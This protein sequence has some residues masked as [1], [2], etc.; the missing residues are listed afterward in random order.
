MKILWHCFCK[1]RVYCIKYKSINMNQINDLYRINSRQSFRRLFV[2]VQHV[3]LDHSFKERVFSMA[4]SNR[5][6]ASG[7][8]FHSDFIQKARPFTKQY[9]SLLF[10]KPTSF[11]MNGCH[12]KWFICRSK[13]S[14]GHWWTT[15]KNPIVRNLSQFLLFYIFMF[16]SYDS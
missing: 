8:N 14:R 2:P 4:Q 10:L 11:F 16:Y 13:T 5:T 15:M 9:V 6:N 7:V 12:N 3:W 1:A